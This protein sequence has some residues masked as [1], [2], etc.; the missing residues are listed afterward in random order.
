MKTF[1]INRLLIK[2]LN[3]KS[4]VIAN[5]STCNES[6]QELLHSL[7]FTYKKIDWFSEYGLW[8]CQIGTVDNRVTS[9][10]KTL[11]MAI[12]LAIL[13]SKGI[14]VDFIHMKRVPSS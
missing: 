3:L 12:C 10:A 7:N 8:R 1:G 2:C 13:K 5:Y 14:E 6:A 9:C 4:G 11:P